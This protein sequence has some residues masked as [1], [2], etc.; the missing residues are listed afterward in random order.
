[1]FAN[2]IRSLFLSSPGMA[3]HTSQGQLLDIVEDTKKEKLEAGDKIEIAFSLLEYQQKAVFIYKG[4]VK[5]HCFRG[6]ETHGFHL[7]GHE[8]L[9][10]EYDSDTDGFTLI[11]P[12]QLEIT[13]EP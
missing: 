9:T 5:S 7:P 2:K 13:T 1:M 8:D 6:Q 10:A 4:L 11:N 3:I 12:N